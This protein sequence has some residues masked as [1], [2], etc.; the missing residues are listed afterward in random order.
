MSGGHRRTERAWIDCSLPAASAEKPGGEPLTDGGAKMLKILAGTTT[1]ALVVAAGV[2]MA[3]SQQETQP[4]GS[5]PGM[6]MGQG[7]GMPM[8]GRQGRPGM[9][10]DGRPMMGDGMGRG[11]MRPHIMLMMMAMVDADGSGALSLEEVQAVHARMFKYADADGDGELTLD[12]MRA[13][14]HGDEMQPAQ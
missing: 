6:M 2:A 8:M 10:Q 9:M 7:Q 11:M 1:A 12:E 13:F 3:Q 14:M 5:Q 4:G